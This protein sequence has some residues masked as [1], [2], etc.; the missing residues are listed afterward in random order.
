MNRTVKAIGAV[1]FA[2]IGVTNL[3][4]CGTLVGARPYI[5]ETMKPPGS[6]EKSS[7]VVL[8]Y[9]APSSEQPKAPT[10]LA[11]QGSAGPAIPS[12]DLYSSRGRMIYV[13]EARSQV[14]AMERNMAKIA[15]LASIK[16]AGAQSAMRPEQRSYQSNMR[17]LQS[18]LDDLRYAS[19]R[20]DVTSN[21]DA[22]DSLLVNLRR[23]VNDAA[24]AIH[25]YVPVESR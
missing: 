2:I 8:G 1:V 22:V 10:S 18:Q 16:G 6:A 11:I 4:G 14:A 21:A 15:A 13:S 12:F 24:S 20:D 19:L 17:E 25:P 7:Q 5:Y 23:N 3:A 9:V